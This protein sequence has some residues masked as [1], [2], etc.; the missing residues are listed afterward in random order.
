MS[1]KL[2]A[3]TLGTFILVFFGCGAAVMSGGDYV[4]TALAFGLALL[5]GIYAF[6]R[7]SGAHYN[8]AVSLGAALSGRVAWAQLPVYIGGQLLGAILG[9][10]CRCSC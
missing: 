4:G 3:E 8:P 7:I 6:G 2:I 9:A 10:R 5:V 1:Q